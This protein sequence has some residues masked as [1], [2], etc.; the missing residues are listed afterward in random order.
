MLLCTVG[1]T[2]K[3]AEEFFSLLKENG[4]AVLLDIRLNNA[5]Q[6]AG[7]TKGKDLAYFLREICAC[8]YVHALE[9]APAKEIFDAYKNKQL[10]WPEFEARY[11]ALLAERGALDGFAAKYAGAEKVCLLC[12]EATPEHCH[13]RLLAEALQSRY[14]EIEVKHL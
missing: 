4:I 12:S 6:L 13:R 8:R 10:T 7:F 3:S 2:Q 11:K 9:F 14:P 5:S 1:F